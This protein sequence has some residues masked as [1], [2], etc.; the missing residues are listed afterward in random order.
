MG[1]R[2]LKLALIAAGVKTGDEVIIPSFTFI[3]TIESILE[4]GAI[5]VIAEIDKSLNMDPVDLEKK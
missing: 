1:Q 3:A 2:R 4:I 5:P